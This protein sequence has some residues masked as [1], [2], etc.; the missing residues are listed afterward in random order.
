MGQALM[1]AAETGL[2]FIQ[3]E[4][5][6]DPRL[7]S[8]LSKA[9]YLQALTDFQTW[10]A[11][12]PLSKS[13]VESYLST[14]QE[15]G[16]APATT[17]KA[18]ASLRWFARR[19]SDKA[20]DELPLEQAQPLALQLDRIGRLHNVRG[21]SLKRGRILEDEEIRSLLDAC[22]SDPGPAGVRDRALIALARSC[23]LRVAEIAGLRM[24]DLRLT[25]GARQAALTIRHGKGN[26]ARSL[27]LAN[28]ALY[29]VEDWL[30]ARG[31]DAGFFFCPINKGGAIAPRRHLSTVALEKILAKRCGEAGIENVSGWHDFR[32]SLASQLIESADVSIAQTLLGHSSPT[33][34]IGYDR[35]PEQTAFDTLVKTV[36]IPYRRGSPRARKGTPDSG[37]AGGKREAVAK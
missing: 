23:G 16:A 8:P 11:G 22:Y 1:P 3:R 25:A 2:E 12:R 35:R 32:R 9:T 17:N 37:L 26:K 31:D 30:T 18:L 29:H 27:P 7:A 10:R 13:L 36:H 14:L 28:G 20:L 21:S 15:R 6:N 5:A 19:L 33:T 4:V 34:T 24:A